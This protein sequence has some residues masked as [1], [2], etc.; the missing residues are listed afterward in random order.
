MANNAMSRRSPT[1][2]LLCAI[3]G[4]VEAMVIASVQQPIPDELLTSL[5]R[6]SGS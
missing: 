1:G 4:P 6:R 2:I 3:G 5:F